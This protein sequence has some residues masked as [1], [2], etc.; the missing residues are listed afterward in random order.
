MK[1]GRVD[2]AHHAVDSWPGQLE[3]HLF[4]RLV[5]SPA[6]QQAFTAASKELV[7]LAADSTAHFVFM[8]QKHGKAL[9]GKVPYLPRPE[10]PLPS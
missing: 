8:P 6:E 7:R 1:V 4:A 3:E 2:P 9:C 10:A 5:Q